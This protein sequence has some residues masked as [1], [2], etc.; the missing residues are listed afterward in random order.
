MAAT[1][2]WKKNINE[3][4]DDSMWYKIKSQTAWKNAQLQVAFWKKI[5]FTYNKLIPKV[6]FLKSSCFHKEKK[7]TRENKEQ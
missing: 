3:R 4:I 2:P 7:I 6:A 5:H 1:A